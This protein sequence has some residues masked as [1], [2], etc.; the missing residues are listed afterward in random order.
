MNEEILH[1]WFILNP[2]YT[3]QSFRIHRA[4]KIIY[5]PSIHSHE[6]ATSFYQQQVGF[7][8]TSNTSKYV[9]VF[10][11]ASMKFREP[12]IRSRQ[13]NRRERQKALQP[14]IYTPQRM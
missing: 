13:T 12:T 1:S 6:C 2:R 5:L 7:V 3:T 10:V 4:I 8:R 9:Y 11:K 14:E